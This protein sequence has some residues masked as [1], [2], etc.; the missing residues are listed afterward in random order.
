MAQTTTADVEEPQP[1]SAEPELEP[2]K[3]DNPVRHRVAGSDG[4]ISIRLSTVALAAAIAVLVVVAGVLAWG[5]H[6]NGT[7]LDAARAEVS[8][9]RA[10][11]DDRQHAQRVASDY[12]VGAAD[13]NFGK[14]D[15]WSARLTANTSP[16][17]ANKLK[18]A[19]ASMEQII[20]P[21]QWISTPTPITATVRSEQNGVFVVNCF[22][23]VLTK[24][25][26]AP[27]GIQSTAT[28]TVTVDKNAGWKITDVGGIDTALSG[29]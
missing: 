22:V 12:S 28:Y 13:M 18:Q 5:M 26:Q 19:A 14:L 6:R 7:E 4:T 24:N 15:D 16:E 1:D 10:A 29:K 27:N 17:L 9:M 8:S 20:V 11:A 23:S 25:T 2:S 21:L 3:A